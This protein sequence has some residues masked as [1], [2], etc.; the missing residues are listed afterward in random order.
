MSDE[1]LSTDA[2]KQILANSIVCQQKHECLRRALLWMGISLA[3]WVG[4]LVFLFATGYSRHARL[5]LSP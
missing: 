1:E 2:A 3:C 5:T 4:T